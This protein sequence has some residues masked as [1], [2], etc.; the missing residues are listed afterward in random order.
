M[1]GLRPYF[2]IGQASA[3]ALALAGCGGG[4]GVTVPTIP[5]PPAVTPPAPA[6][7]PTPTPTPTSS[8][9]TAEYR[10]SAAA[11]VQAV[12]AYDRGASGQGI[13]VAVI[14]SGVNPALAEFAGRIAVASRDVA[15]SRPLSDE[16]GHG[17][18]VT[19]VA[20]AA[21]NNSGIHG[22][23]PQATLL[24]LRADTPGSCDDAGCSYASPAIAAGFDAALA[25][26]ARVINVSLGGTATSAGLRAAAARVSSAG[27]VLVVSAGNE[28]LPSPEGF[29]NQLTAAGVA[30]TLVVGAINEA[31]EIADFSNRAGLLASNFLVAPGV[32]VRSFNQEGAAFLYNG[33]SIAAPVVSGSVALLAQAFPSLTGAQIVEILLRTA[34]DLG[35]PGVDVI[36]GHGRLNVTRAFQPVAGLTAAGSGTPLTLAGGTL[37]AALGDGGAVREA[38]A[39]VPALDG[40]ARPFTV[41]LG[42]GLAMAAPGRLATRLIGQPGLRASTENAAFRLSADPRTLWAGDRATM[43]ALAPGMAPVGSPS[44][45]VRLALGSG[46]VI[47]AGHGEAATSLLAL[48]DTTASGPDLIT[49]DLALPPG[50]RPL[51][52]AALA[53]PLGRFM[54][55]A[56]IGQALLP[57]ERGA[58]IA[59]QSTALLRLSRRWQGLELAGLLRLDDER[60]SLAGTRLASGF[61]LAGARTLSLGVAARLDLGALALAA[62]WRR[63]RSQLAL[64]P[65]LIA[66]AGA[67]GGDA[68]S[69]SLSRGGVAMAGDQLSLGVT[70]PLALGGP[71]WLAGRSDAVWLGPR[72][73]EIAVEASYARPLAASGR[74]QLSLFHRANPGHVASVAADQGAA[75]QFFW[76][77]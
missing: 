63:A 39:A 4:G 9:N 42:Q 52:G 53:Q 46:Q 14:D 68:A 45:H 8:F 13:T 72:V 20:L 36:Y 22:L 40:Y 33:T 54:L 64:A 6:P 19:A 73:R 18:S 48:A 75:V 62:D 51:G 41:D 57:M 34:D 59:R 43:A 37:G 56:G 1:S 66:A 15:G 29:A 25:G 7:T 23:A 55:A 58:A 5:A 77:W 32:S 76:G 69:L 30:T 17:T 12:A 61:G 35:A 65:G 44:G 16:R 11:A 50:S 26:G 3:L 2:L 71:L 47:A 10:R 70:R 49:A 74:L 38:L 28:S 24:A 21:R 27:V 31:G 67:F 60:G